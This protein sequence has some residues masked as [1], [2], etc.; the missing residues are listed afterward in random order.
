[1][2]ICRLNDG[3]PASELFS[4]HFVLSCASERSLLLRSIASSELLLPLPSVPDP[5]CE[6]E[7]KQPDQDLLDSFAKVCKSQGRSD[8]R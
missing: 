8:P 7:R 4:G 2:L 6:S 5:T 3:S 1:M